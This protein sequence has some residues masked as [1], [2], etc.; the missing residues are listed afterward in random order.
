[1][2]TSEPLPATVKLTLYRGDTRVWTDVIE[3]NTGT[4]TAPVWTP[5]DLTG[6]TFLAQI[7][8]DRNRTDPVVATIAVEAVDAPNGV[9]TRTLTATEA[10]KLGSDGSRL[11]WDLQITRTSDGFRRTYMAGPVTVKGDA[12]DD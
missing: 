5:K 6:H 2:A 8:S 9:I 4:E 10:D 1:M 11:F 7:R 3:E 12:S